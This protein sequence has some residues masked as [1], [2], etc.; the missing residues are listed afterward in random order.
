MPRHSIIIHTYQSTGKQSWLEFGAH[1]HDHR[2][3]TSWSYYN[4]G[5]SPAVQ[6]GSQHTLRVKIIYVIC[7]EYKI[8]RLPFN[9]RSWVWVCRFLTAHQHTKGYIQCHA[10][11]KSRTK[12]KWDLLIDKKVWDRRS[13]TQECVHLVMLLQTAFAHHLSLTRWSWYTNLT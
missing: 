5:H 2:Q 4:L 12:C 3:T 1:P 9:R 13:T 6:T 8:T 10:M 7:T 11:V